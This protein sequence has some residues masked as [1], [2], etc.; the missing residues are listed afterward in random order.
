MN[1]G[2]EG[3]HVKLTAENPEVIARAMPRWNQDSEYFRLLDSEPPRLLSEK[4]IK[5]W[6]EKDLDKDDPDGFFFS[7]KLKEVDQVIGFMGLFNLQWNHGDALAAIG[8]GEREHWGKGYGTEAMHILLAY[9]FNEL[10]LRRVTLIV[11]D[12]NGRARRSY[13]KAGFVVEGRMRGM[14]LREGQR[15]D[16]LS[17]GVLKE[18]WLRMEEAMG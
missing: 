14:M 5:E 1:T 2:F 11:F 3:R 7:I 9:A 8:I 17:M 12:Y 18:E 6:F 13:E 16:M 4:K 10:N 15:W